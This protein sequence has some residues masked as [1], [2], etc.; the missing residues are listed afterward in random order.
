MTRK[1]RPTCPL[2]DRPAP[3]RGAQ[4]FGYIVGEIVST[5]VSFVVIGLLVWALV[6]IVR[7]I[8]R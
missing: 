2:C 6:A 4:A 1:A 5:L 8:A 7:G 3:R